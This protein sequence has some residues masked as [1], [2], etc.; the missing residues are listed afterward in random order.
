MKTLLNYLLT[1]LLIGL[2]PLAIMVSANPDKE[3]LNWLF[4]WIGSTIAL[5]LL[6][7]NAEEEIKKPNF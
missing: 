6:V 5:S 2:I 7:N 1:I 4:I 3:N